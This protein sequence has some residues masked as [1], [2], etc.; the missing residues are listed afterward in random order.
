MTE[1]SKRQAVL[2]ASWRVLPWVGMLMIKVPTV[3]AGFLVIPLLYLYRHRNFDDVPKIFLPWQNPEDWVDGPEGTEHSLPQWWVNREGSGFYSWWHY[4][5]VRNPA[6]GLRNY[7]WVDL[8]IVPDKVKFWTPEYLRFYEPWHTRKHHPELKSYG[9][10]CWQD[11]RMG[12]KF[13]H[14]W[15]DLERDIVWR[16]PNVSKLLPWHWLS[17]KDLP[18]MVDV[19]LV[20]KGPKHLTLKFGWR[21]GPNDALGHMDPDGQ[22]ALDGAGFA[23]KILIYRDG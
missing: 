10:I 17:W 8:E 6:N 23:S 20:E 19:T 5:A 3:L 18:N 11:W 1:L 15:P 22:R 13:V 9:Y 4:H 2:G 21:I 7:E 12:V 14:I 16:I